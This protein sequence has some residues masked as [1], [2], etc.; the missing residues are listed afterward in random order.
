MLLAIPCRG[1]NQYIDEMVAAIDSMTVKPAH[2]LYMA[3][4]PTA[5][6]ALEARKKL[7]GNALIEYYPITSKPSY[8][9]RPQMTYGEDW[10]LTGH[11][12]NMAVE[13]I[14]KHADIDAVVFIDGDCIPEPYLRL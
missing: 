2:V 3:D 14:D 1:Q 8:V 11:V 7:A 10:F 9:G 4:R 12:R 13:Y 6:E 5:R